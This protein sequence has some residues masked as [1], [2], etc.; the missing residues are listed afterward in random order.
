MVELVIKAELEL[1]EMREI[2]ETMDPV[3]EEV[4]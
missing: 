4:M 3:V 1:L 2:L